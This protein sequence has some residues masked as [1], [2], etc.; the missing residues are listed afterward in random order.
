MIGLP[1]EVEAG[2]L[3]SQGLHPGS[4]L[5]SVFLL[6]E[7]AALTATWFACSRVPGASGRVL[8]VAG[9]LAV[10]PIFQGVTWDH[11][12][13]VEILVVVLLAPMLRAG[14]LAWILA[15]GGVLLT[16]VNQQVID[17][18]LRVNGLEP[19]HGVAQL[20]LFGAGA[21]I[22]LIGMLANLAAVLLVARLQAGAAYSPAATCSATRSTLLGKAAPL[23]FAESA[24]T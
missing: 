1:R 7:V 24:P 15:V 5:G 4:G 6:V 9:L 17:A 19:P 18:S 20:A 13:T 2:V 23:T 10:V 21:S 22:D 12:L 11:H 16:G 14:S 8:T 3:G